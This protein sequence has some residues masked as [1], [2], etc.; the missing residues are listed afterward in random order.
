MSISEITSSGSVSEVARLVCSE[1]Q[2]N[3]F[4]PTADNCPDYDADGENGCRRYDQQSVWEG[5]RDLTYYAQDQGML[6]VM[7]ASGGITYV[8]RQNMSTNNW[9]TV[10]DV[11]HLVAD[12]LLPVRS[13]L[14][15]QPWSMGWRHAS[16]TTPSLLAAV[17]RRFY[18][19]QRH[20]QWLFL[21]PLYLP[22]QSH[23]QRHPLYLVALAFQREPSQSPLHTP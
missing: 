23:L 17:A 2:C 3:K 6:W 14:V 21:L 19:L 10:V 12:I 22:L 1:G 5:I 9:K 20:P 18:L 15:Q 7:T 11:H 8:F 13:L 16:A 4:C